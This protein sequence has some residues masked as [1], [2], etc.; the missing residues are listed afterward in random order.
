MPD[1]VDHRAA[2][3]AGV[4]ASAA[5]IAVMEID[6]RV[7][8]VNTDDLILLGRPLAPKPSWAKPIGTVIH[9][10]N[11]A[12]FG[13]LYARFVRDQLPGPPWFRGVI[14]ANI[15]NSVLYPLCLLEDLHPA[16]RDGQI[17]RYATKIAYLQSVPRH[18][19]FGIVLGSLYDRLRRR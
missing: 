14:F 11:G 7:V 16:V 10:V 8:G 13:L 19:I 9:L 1:H 4:A 15:E 3:I 17:D 5:Y 6:R 12:T 2:A 18:I